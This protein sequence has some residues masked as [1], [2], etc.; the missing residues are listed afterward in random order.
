MLLSGGMLAYPA[1][2]LVGVA[3]YSTGAGAIAGYAI[4]AVFAC[5][6]VLAVLYADRSTP[7]RRWLLL[8]V[9]TALFIAQLPF[10]REFA[11]FL[12][13]VVVCYA[14]LFH[15]RHAVAIVAAGALSAIL[16]PLAV[17][18]WHSGPAWFQAVALV[19]TA[20]AVSAFAE[21]AAANFALLEARAEV[22]RLASE[23]ER[24]RI[25]RDLHDLLGH[26]LTVITV[27]SGLARRLAAT[28][29]ARSLQ[30]ITEV[31]GLSRQ[32][33]TE[34]RAAVSGYR[35]VTLGSELARGRELLRASG[36]VADLPKATDQVPAA[37]QELFGWVVR[38]GLTNVVRHARAD[39]CTVTLSA[40]EVEIRDNGVGGTAGA[41]NGLTGLRER[42]AAAGGTVAAGPLSPHGWR[43]LVSL[44]P[45]TGKAT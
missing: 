1:L 44:K 4:A 27:K 31:E 22:A 32:A 19:F 15:R 17:R 35:E 28:D 3:Q 23:A 39:H 33:L 10:A 21:I 12:A 41:G 7:S 45:P 16:L 37:H 13:T 24:T 26:S 2:S 38:E 20:M 29:P 9:M 43:L 42:V 14:A 40:L 5:C 34:V 25:A 36:I 18:P 30:E 6:Y 11:F 8:T